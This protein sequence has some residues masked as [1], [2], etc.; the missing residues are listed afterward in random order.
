VSQKKIDSIINKNILN[1]IK[2]PLLNRINKLSCNIITNT[3][4]DLTETLWDLKENFSW[5]H[6]Y[7]NINL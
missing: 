1:M 4:E 5:L 6:E 7:S 2:Y 3:V